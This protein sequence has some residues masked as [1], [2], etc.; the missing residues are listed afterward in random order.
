MRAYEQPRD[1]EVALCSARTRAHARRANTRPARTQVPRTHPRT[2]IL[3]D[4]R[5]GEDGF[6]A[7]L[8]V[9]TIPASEKASPQRVQR[10]GRGVLPATTTV[11]P[12]SRLA[13]WSQHAPS[14]Q[15]PPL[16][17]TACTMSS[18]PSAFGPPPHTHIRA[19]SHP[20]THTRTHR[21]SHMRIA[22]CLPTV[23]P[24]RPR[25]PPPLPLKWT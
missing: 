12:L 1:W 13:F 22:Q 21:H 11:R 7:K 8:R 24:P 16:H 5:P 9:T 17:A 18:A 6:N 23:P 25:R 4:C 3:P 15:H 14:M 20:H 2:C 10:E 19:H